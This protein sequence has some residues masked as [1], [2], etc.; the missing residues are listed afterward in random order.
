MI[1][2]TATMIG[3]HMAIAIATIGRIATIGGIATIVGIATIDGN[4]CN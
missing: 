3:I 4:S 1:T 2:V